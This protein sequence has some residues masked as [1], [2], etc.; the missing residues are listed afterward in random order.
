MND[1][2]PPSPQAEA[3]EPPP[4]RCGGLPQLNRNR[5]PAWAGKYTPISMAWATVRRLQE[6]DTTMVQG[7]P[8]QLV[9]LPQPAR[10]R[11]GPAAP[12]CQQLRRSRRL[13]PGQRPGPHF[14]ML[15]AT[16]NSP[17]A[18]HPLS[19]HGR[20][21]SWRLPSHRNTL[22][23]ILF[24]P[25]STQFTQPRLSVHNKPTFVNDLHIIYPGL[26]RFS[27]VIVEYS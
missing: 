21:S 20:N 12:S 17:I 25:F 6:E 9:Q 1:G 23:S 4:A 5:S 18:L 13:P 8:W 16:W 2:G 11:P 3:R 10:T 24:Q 7:A 27:G 19:Q 22:F 26:D 14:S 15:P